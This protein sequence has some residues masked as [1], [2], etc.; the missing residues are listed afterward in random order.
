MITLKS[1]REKFKKIESRKKKCEWKNVTE[2]LWYD[3]FQ[4]MKNRKAE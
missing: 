3:K 4:Y 2:K 1:R